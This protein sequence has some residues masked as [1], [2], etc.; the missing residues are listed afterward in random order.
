VAGARKACVQSRQLSK[1]AEPALKSEKKREYPTCTRFDAPKAKE[2]GAG[3]CE[4]FAREK[5]RKSMTTSRKLNEAGQEDSE[6][7]PR[8]N[9]AKLEA[10]KRDEAAPHS[11]SVVHIV[12]QGNQRCVCSS[13][14][15]PYHYLVSTSLKLPTK[16]YAERASGQDRAA[17]ASCSARSSSVMGGVCKAW[18]KFTATW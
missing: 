3:A 2:S 14:R 9:V 5:A 6:I 12:W 7:A 13:S 10:V 8:S 18:F 1:A 4:R 16:P 15:F 11:V 17:V